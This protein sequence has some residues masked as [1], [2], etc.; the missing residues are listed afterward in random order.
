MLNRRPYVEEDRRLTMKK[1]KKAEYLARSEIKDA[2]P[3][4]KHLTEEV[5]TCADTIAMYPMDLD[6]TLGEHLPSEDK[7]LRQ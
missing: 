5:M 1:Q 4:L 6:I 3:D 7:E 2:R